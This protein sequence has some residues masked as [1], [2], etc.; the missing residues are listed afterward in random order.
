MHTHSARVWLVQDM[1]SH[2]CTT[3]IWWGCNWHRKLIPYILHFWQAEPLVEELMTANTYRERQLA[4]MG[5]KLNMTKSEI[6]S[7]CKRKQQA[8]TVLDRVRFDLHQASCLIQEP[9][10][11]KE[12]VK[13]HTML[14]HWHDSVA[15][16]YMYTEFVSISFV[17]W[18][19]HVYYPSGVW[20]NI[21]NELLNNI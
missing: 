7:Q 18:Q 21:E 4:E 13:V 12:T 9:T 1:K 6:T 19:S 2:K 8:H 11:L 17:S 16:T 10:K 3:H 5:Q 15:I 14:W 20:N